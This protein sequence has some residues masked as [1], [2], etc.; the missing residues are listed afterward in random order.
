M[1]RP[2]SYIPGVS[3]PRASLLS[4]YLPPLADGVASSWLN[5]RLPPG[6]WVLDPFGAAPR[7]SLEMAR[8]GYRVLVSANN[9]VS[10]KL[11]E[12]GAH[13]PAQSELKSALAD[14]ASAYKGQ[15]RI[16]PHIR[17]LYMTECSA[18]GEQVM[19]TYFVWERSA[20]FPYARHYTCTRCG[21]SGEHPTTPK[22]KERAASFSGSDLNRARALER[23]APTHDPDRVHAEEALSVYLPR[24]VYAL[25]T[26]IN[27]LDSLDITP[28]RRNYLSALLLTACDQANSLWSHST[29]RERPRQLTIPS[30]FR[31][32]NVWLAL[33]QSTQLWLSDQPDVPLTIWPK[34]TNEQAGI[35]LFEGRLRD[36]TA[37]LSNLKIG[38]V[39]AAL[40]RPNQA[41]WTLSALWTAWLWGREA[42]GPFKSVLRRRRYDW[43]WHTAALF[44][45][46]HSLAGL[47]EDGTPILSLVGEAEPGFLSAAILSAASAEFHLEGIAL[48]SE[49]QQAQ[50]SWRFHTQRELQLHQRSKPVNLAREAGLSVLKELGQPA[51]Y[52]TVHTA[53]LAALANGNALTQKLVKDEPYEPQTETEVSPTE[54]Y[55]QLQ[56]V[57]KE[58]FN[59]RN[60]FRRF[61]GSE[62]SLEVGSWW[63][64][65]E[66]DRQISLA[67]RIEIAIAQYLERHASCTYRDLDLYLCEAF[68]G[69]LTPNP[70]LILH[71]LGSYGEE[72]P[73][74]S[75]QWKLRYQD[76]P[77]IRH[78]EMETTADSL[79]N[80][81]SRLGFLAQRSY[82]TNKTDS[83]AESRI[84]SLWLNSQ[85]ISKYE[86]S[87][88]TSAT[89]GEIV[90]QKG[91]EARK[92]QLGIRQVIVLPGGRANL[93][94]YKL[95]KDKNLKK[96]VDQ[97]WIFLKF[98]HLRRLMDNPLLSA[99]N[100]IEQLELDPLTYTATQIRLL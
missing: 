60:G 36:L 64:R 38:A 18:C 70:E 63:L 56:N 9:P 4:R 90:R 31:E 1:L 79:S 3:A 22:D 95:S 5:Q 45:G 43:A 27:K 98:R 6:S 84:T 53:A 71:C 61:E 75:N 35:T 51:D 42:V 47:L 26:L 44:A 14:L 7:L 37:G 87:I 34:I 21:E 12:M 40:P 94:A 69:L 82:P 92:S 32:N 30:H 10:R 77:D 76:H 86:F 66:G 65:D 81:A 59:F 55:S 25:F 85:G 11:L 15:E 52:L 78:L 58:V 17:S 48:R 74:G 41:F 28:I 24:A 99:E 20:T 39:V 49:N 97:G 2:I 57:L 67:D 68:P 96:E 93:A 100:F 62:V 19:A 91:M 80:L 89:I 73:Q 54:T 46:F 72:Q 29:S 83:L 16:E 23:V 13:A 8:A 88:I 50:I 33:E